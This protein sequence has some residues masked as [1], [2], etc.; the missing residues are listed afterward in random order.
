MLFG[1]N[2]FCQPVFKHP[3]FAHHRFD[4]WIGEQAFGI[5]GSYGV[6]D[7]TKFLIDLCD[8][9]LNINA[10]VLTRFS[11]KPYLDMH[12]QY[13]QNVGIAFCCF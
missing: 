2:V 9:D 3:L 11:A 13:L 5:F 6:Q 12:F 1:G 10:F 7:A 4:A 8:A